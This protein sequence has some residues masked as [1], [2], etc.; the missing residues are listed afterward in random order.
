MGRK[1]I[2]EKG[3]EIKHENKTTRDNHLDDKIRKS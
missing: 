3:Q 1:I 2:K